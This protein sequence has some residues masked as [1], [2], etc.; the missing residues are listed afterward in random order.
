MVPFISAFVF[1]Y[2]I[3]CNN[4]IG[5]RT[6]NAR[7]IPLQNLFYISYTSCSMHD[8]TVQFFAPPCMISMTSHIGGT[9]KTITKWKQF[10]NWQNDKILIIYIKYI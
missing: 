10:V 7:F 8:K 2:R 3:N 9:I 5:G 6:P 1:I 4:K